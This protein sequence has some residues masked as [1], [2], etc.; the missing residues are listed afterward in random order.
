MKKFVVSEEEKK[1][2]IEQYQPVKTDPTEQ[3]MWDKG[4]EKALRSYMKMG[5]PDRRY[6]ITVEEPFEFETTNSDEYHKLKHILIKT[7]TKF[8]HSEEKI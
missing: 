6:K 8:T 7:H 2:I 1:K 3:I 4:N 5:E